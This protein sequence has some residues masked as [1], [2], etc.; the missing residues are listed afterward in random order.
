LGRGKNGIGAEEIVSIP[1]FFGPA[2]NC[3]ELGQ[4]GY[5][6]TGYHLVKSNNEIKI[7]YCAFQRPAQGTNQSNI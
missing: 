1:P 4:L 6:L 5:T 2:T 3:Q 7:V